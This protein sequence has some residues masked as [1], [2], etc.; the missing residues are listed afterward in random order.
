MGRTLGDKSQ[1]PNQPEVRHIAAQAGRAECRST[2]FLR[3]AVARLEQPALMRPPL[4]RP[5]DLP[6]QA[7]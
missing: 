7:C 6:D 3:T 2:P 5:E 1:T 4:R